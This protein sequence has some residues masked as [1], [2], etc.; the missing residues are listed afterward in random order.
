MACFYVKEEW[1]MSVFPFPAFIM[2]GQAGLKSLLQEEG[3]DIIAKGQ[4][5]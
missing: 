3:E 1:K 4:R 2:A 5:R